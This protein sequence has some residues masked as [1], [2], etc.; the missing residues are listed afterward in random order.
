MF[1]VISIIVILFIVVMVWG[2]L[3][4]KEERANPGRFHNP[5]QYKE[6][7]WQLYH[8]EIRREK[9]RTLFNMIGQPEE[10]QAQVLAAYDDMEGNVDVFKEW[11]KDHEAENRAQE[12]EHQAFLAAGP[13]GETQQ[14]RIDRACKEAGLTKR[15][16]C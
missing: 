14:E 16:D 15:D 1:I 8:Q 4:N 9:E 5:Q 12:R 13:A 6:E 3:A 11:L 2:G 10:V 7:K